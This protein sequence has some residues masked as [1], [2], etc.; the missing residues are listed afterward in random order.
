VLPDFAHESLG[1]WY[2]KHYTSLTGRTKVA[3][4][5]DTYINYHDTHI[6]KAAIRLL[7]DCGYDVVLA[8]VGCCQRPLISNGFL[9]KAKAQ[10][11]MVADALLPFIRQGMPV[12]VC[13][14]SCTSA[15]TDDIPDL[16]DDA[17]TARILQEK[18][19]AID[20]FLGK[21]MEAGRLQGSFQA[22]SDNILLHG[23]CHQKSGPGVGEMK[24]VYDTI[25]GLSITIP[26]SG[27]CG[28]AG[29]FGY[30]KE[31]Y[32]LS[33]S[34]AN[35]ELAPAIRKATE[36]T[37]IVANGFSCRHQIQDVCHQKPVH[38]V[39]SIVFTPA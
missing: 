23:H 30:E 36:G 37:L 17:E 39:E 24:S 26:D 2:Q 12:L 6:G 18:V 21:E 29:A 28:M 5:A 33:L 15:L 19:M 10:G 32:N 38:W 20:V 34:I 16:I 13:E 14:P 4:F 27:C 3:L 31:H 9:K 25:E 7:N 8:N 1:A 35:L 11:R 22:K